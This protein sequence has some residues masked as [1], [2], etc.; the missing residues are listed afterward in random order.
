M[1]T[2][3]GK[4]T[5]VMSMIA[6]GALLA[7]FQAATQPGKK[8]A[9]SPG[10]KSPP[11]SGDKPAAPKTPPPGMDDAMQKA[12]EAAA[13]PGPEHARL[14]KR[15]GEWTSKTSMTM[16]G[17]PL[18]PEMGPS[19]ASGTAT[20]KTILGGR[21]IQQDDSGT[22]MGQPF[23]A[24]RVI[25]YNNGS[26]KYEATWMYTMGTGMMMMT[27]ESKDSGKTVEWNASFDNEM[28][29]KEAI[30]ITTTE[31]DDD[32]FTVSMK[33]TDPAAGDMV[34]EAKYTRKK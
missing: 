18:P 15:A 14:A 34:M 23:T 9:P 30:H 10:A 21:F 26:K 8:P 31:I 20:I 29:V 3:R 7:G 13:K 27:G 17:K 16:G 28:G 33:S 1:L 11:P 5:V 19:E 6:A 2:T 22:M 25:G 4:W 32:H 12:M 24:T